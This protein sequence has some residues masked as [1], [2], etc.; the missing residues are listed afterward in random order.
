M[1]GSPTSTHAAN[2]SAEPL[3]RFNPRSQS[4]RDNGGAGQSARVPPD[5]RVRGSGRRHFARPPPC[6]RCVQTPQNRVK[7]AFLQDVYRSIKRGLFWGEKSGFWVPAVKL[8]PSE[9]PEFGGRG[10]VPL[11]AGKK[12]EFGA[13]RGGALSHV[14]QEP[15]ASQ[16]TAAPQR[17]QPH[18]GSIAAP[19]QPTGTSAP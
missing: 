4:E 8:S 5:R 2:Q 12:G 7:F 9:T 19:Q 15:R 6:R 17:L 1:R 16:P 3:S 11:L 13:A 14:I 10:A 18:S